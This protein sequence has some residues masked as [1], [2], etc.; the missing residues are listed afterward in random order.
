LKGN[1][2][3]KKID[4]NISDPYMTLK[5]WSEFVQKQIK[6][7]GSDVY[8]YTDAGPNNVMLYVEKNT[9]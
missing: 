9:G 2:M 3:K 4:L 8:M 5:E 6:E 1:N 7:Y